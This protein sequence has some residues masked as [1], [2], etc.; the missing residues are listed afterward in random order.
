MSPLQIEAEVA[1]RQESLAATA[2]A[3][4]AGRLGRRRRRAAARGAAHLLPAPRTRPVA[5]STLMPVG[6]S[7]VG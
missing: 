2:R 4:R 7:R 5:E 3:V 1:Y 6:V